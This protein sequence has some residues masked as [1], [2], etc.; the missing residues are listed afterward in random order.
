MYHLCCHPSQTLLPCPPSGTLICFCWCAP[1]SGWSVGVPPQS[2][3]A[4]LVGSRRYTW[5][6]GLSGQL[7]HGGRF[8]CAIPK[9]VL[10]DPLSCGPGVRVVRISVGPT[11]T[12]AIDA[13][14]RLFTWGDGQVLPCVRLCVCICVCE[15]VRTRVRFHL[16][17][18]ALT[19][20][21]V[22][23]CSP[24]LSSTSSSAATAFPS[25]LPTRALAAAKVRAA[26]PWQHLLEALFKHTHTHSPPPPACSLAAAAVWAAGPWHHLLEAFFKYTLPP[27]PRLLPGCCRSSGS[28]AMGAPRPSSTPARCKP[29]RGCS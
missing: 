14:G 19:D 26:G 10:F 11:H 7:G 4:T 24:L 9:R 21:P 5:G 8:P 16:T 29:W 25:P 28:W 13:D 20:K 2:S 6:R 22:P 1:P 12:A 18:N 3:L 27:S 23:F 15:C 17:L